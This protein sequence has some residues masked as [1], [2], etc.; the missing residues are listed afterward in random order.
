MKNVFIYYE[1]N[2]GE[3]ADD[4]GACSGIRIFSDKNKVKRQIAETLKIYAGSGI[5]DPAYYT[6]CDRFVVDK[7]ILENA[8][9]N[10]HEN[11]RLTD[12]QIIILIESKF[13]NEN[14]CIT[15]FADEQE[16]WGENFTIH[17][18]EMVVE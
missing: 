18:D 2:Y 15:L 6:S 7:D 1:S 17:A 16:N 9:I 10:V 12:D 14:C 4:C 3:L 11:N 5:K 13:K 8:G